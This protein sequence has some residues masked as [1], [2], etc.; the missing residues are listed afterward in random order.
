VTAAG[1]DDRIAKARDARLAL[2]QLQHEADV[3]RRAA[4]EI[5]RTAERSRLASFSRTRRRP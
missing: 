2:E 4:Q 3:L 1:R 5:R